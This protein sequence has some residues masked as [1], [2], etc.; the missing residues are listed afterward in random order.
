MTRYEIGIDITRHLI[1]RADANNA[2]D[3]IKEATAR[4]MAGNPADDE[5]AASIE[6]ATITTTATATPVI[7]IVRGREC[8]A[9]IDGAEIARHHDLTQLVQ[10]ADAA[11]N[12]E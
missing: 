10:L 1:Y 2:R 11:L 12:G 8:Q 4:A 6:I 9:L 7:N 3:A 5:M